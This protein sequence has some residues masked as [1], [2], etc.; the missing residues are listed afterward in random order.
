MF[1]RIII[2]LDLTE[3]AEVIA[4]VIKD[5]RDESQRKVFL[6]HVVD[7]DSAGPMAGPLKFADQKALRTI[8]DALTRKGMLVKTKVAVGNP[9]TEVL[10]Y[11]DEVG[12]GLVAV[13]SHNKGQASA[14]LLGSV[15]SEVISRSKLPVLVLKSPAAN[16]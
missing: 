3:K 1:E 9:A 2:A 7:M 6:I 5:F 16:G 15:S 12:A 11:A 14:I 4:S 13:G 8:A 10:A